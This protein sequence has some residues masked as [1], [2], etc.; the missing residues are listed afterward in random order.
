[1]EKLKEIESGSPEEKLTQREENFQKE[2]KKLTHE[3]AGERKTIAELR[4]FIDVLRIGWS[5]DKKKLLK[6]TEKLNEIE[7]CSTENKIKKFEND[8]FSEHKKLTTKDCCIKMKI[9]SDSKK[10]IYKTDERDDDV[11]VIDDDP[12]R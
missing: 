9:S 6:A 7:V 11:I 4:N 3:L 8:N 10:K 2:I 1:M 5:S 12:L